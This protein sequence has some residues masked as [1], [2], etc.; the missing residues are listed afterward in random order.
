MKHEALYDEKYLESFVKA[1]LFEAELDSYRNG[2][3][4]Q[5]MEVIRGS[6]G[7]GGLSLWT[8]CGT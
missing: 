7:F 4:A 3:P 2:K 1:I 5:F 6:I 8:N